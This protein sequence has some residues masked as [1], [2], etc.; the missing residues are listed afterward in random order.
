[1]YPLWGRGSQGSLKLGTAPG[2]HHRTGIWDLD[3]NLTQMVP[4]PVMLTVIQGAVEN[5]LAIPD[6]ELL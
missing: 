1:M 5:G 2:K 6:M 4:V 3:N